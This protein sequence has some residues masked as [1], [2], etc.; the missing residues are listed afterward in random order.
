MSDQSGAGE[1]AAPESGSSEGASSFQSS[2]GTVVVPATPPRSD[3][4]QSSEDHSQ[5]AADA[6]DR[7]TDDREEA[8]TSVDDLQSRLRASR[9]AEKALNRELERFRQA[10]KAREDANKTELQRATERAEA[11]ESKVAAL[12]RTNLAQQIAAEVGIPDWADKLDGD[13]ARSMR[14]DAQRIRDRLP[15]SGSVSPGMEGGVRG[16]GALPQPSSMD[17][18]IRGGTRR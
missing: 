17:D 6:A 18:L 10:E 5:S 8:V 13:D 14:A 11:A 2:Q 4:N 9:R 3:A 7:D 16:L 15:N 12:E 1:T